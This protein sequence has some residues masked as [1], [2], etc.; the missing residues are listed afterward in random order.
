MLKKITLVLS[1]CLCVTSFAGRQ[2]P[3][4]IGPCQ[5]GA[6]PCTCMQADRL[7]QFAAATF[8]SPVSAVSWCCLPALNSLGNPAIHLAV[9]GESTLLPVLPGEEMDVNVLVRLYELDLFALTFK[10]LNS[11]NLNNAIT[12]DAPVVNALD[13]C[14]INNQ[15]FLVAGGYNL[16]SDPYADVVVFAFDN[17]SWQVTGTTRVPFATAAT[18]GA[19]F[20]TYDSN[21]AVQV[22]AVST[23][24]NPCSNSDLPFYLAVGGDS[25]NAT[26]QLSI[27]PFEYDEDYFFNLDCNININLSLLAVYGIDWCTRGANSQP[28]LAVGGEKAVSACN[29]VP[30]IFVYTFNGIC[31]DSCPN[32]SLM[33]QGTF[34]SNVVDSVQWC[35]NAGVNCPI[36]PLLA[37]GGATAA[38]NINTRTYYINQ[39]NYSLNSYAYADDNGLKAI[40]SV[41]WNPA[42]CQCTNLTVGGCQIDEENP[43][44]NV[45]V[46]KKI[47]NAT[48]LNLLT[49]SLFDTNV[50]SLD[51][52]KTNTLPANYCAYLALGTTGTLPCEGGYDCTDQVF[53]CQAKFCQS[54]NPNSP[55][56]R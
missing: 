42:P 39:N 29:S 12:G 49:S 40:N 9:A 54:A 26:K 37:V 16:Q 35:C 18:D 10:E 25:V 24:C 52:C 41:A 50:T 31:Q 30:N 33:T 43:V 34:D 4:R 56:Q 13:W 1:A 55:C 15:Y 5:P 11:Y 8:G 7:F 53:V 36:L 14:C 21:E 45:D 22:H 2:L 48:K 47:K 19:Y 51:W 20:Y 28:L 3:K 23:L 27:V 38:N 46:Y 17:A 32:A 44:C 6:A